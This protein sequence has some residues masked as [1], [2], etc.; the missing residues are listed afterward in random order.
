[1][2]APKNGAVAAVILVPLWRSTELGDRN[3][4]GDL[5][6]RMRSF[7]RG[8]T[9]IALLVLVFVGSQVAAQQCLSSCAAD[10]TCTFDGLLNTP[11]GDATLS[12][13]DQCQMVVQGIGGSGEDGVV[14]SDLNSTVMS[15][16]LAT[17]N[18]S[19]SII[20][21]KAT[22]TQLGVVD[23][24]PDK[25]VMV[26]TIVNFNGDDV[27]TI[28]DCSAI[29][30]LGYTVEIYQGL[31]L[32]SRQ[33]VGVG[34]PS[35]FYPREDLLS[36]T[37]GI[38]PNGDV[39]TAIR[40]ENPQPIRV[41]TPISDPGPFT[42]DLI[43]VFA[44]KPGLIPTLQTAI[45]NVFFNTGDVTMSSMFAGALQSR[46]TSNADELAAGITPCDFDNP[47]EDNPA[48]PLAAVL[49][50]GRHSMVGDYV[51]AFTTLINPNP[52]PGETLHGCGIAP[53]GLAFDHVFRFQATDPLTNA[54]TGLPNTPV[55]IEPGGARTFAFALQASE[56]VP[57]TE[58]GLVFG[59]ENTAK[60]ETVSGVNTFSFSASGAPVPD[61]VAVAATLNNDGIV[62]IPANP[63]TGVFAVATVNVGVGGN[64]TASADTGSATLPVNVTICETDPPT[65]LCL[66]PPSSSVDTQIDA[67]ETPTFGIF[68]EG[69]G[70][71]PFDPAANRIYV[72][73]NSGTENRGATSVA[74]RSQP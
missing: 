40:L 20:G 15:T 9:V 11:L 47:G 21:S 50:T 18:F 55:D 33:N 65:G 25:E 69:T 71:V 54:L 2:P 56:E 7:R 26:T 52:G 17:P 28:V 5:I 22:I 43:L 68:V 51:A 62:N 53:N 42:G 34:P 8:T 36:L 24:Q 66:A 41:E 58:L 64:I 61:I 23:G 4:E 12:I 70:D 27:K 6:I 44:N 38:E 48:S 35:L 73:F 63:G 19:G 1:M 57:Q 37:C 3:R 30:V 72:R 39:F 10:G 67:N 14:Q 13:N 31:V 16:S 59:C 60:T 45:Q 74:V 46:C 49:P 29:E 32:V